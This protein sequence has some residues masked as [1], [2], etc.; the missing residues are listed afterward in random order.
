MILVGDLMQETAGSDLDNKTQAFVAN[1]YRHIPESSLPTYP[2]VLLMLGITG[3]PVAGYMTGMILPVLAMILI[4][5]FFYLRKLPK[6]TGMPPSA[7]KWLD[8]GNLFKHL[9]SLFLI[10]GLI[11]IFNLSVLTATLIT[12]ALA[13]IV[14]RFKVSDIWSLMQEAVEVKMLVNTFIVLVF[15]TFMEETGAM[16]ALPTFFAQFPIPL[17]ISFALLFFVGGV[18]SGS[19]GII[20]LAAPMA[21]LAIPNGGV[22][23]MVLLMTMSHIASLVSPT[24]VCVTIVADYYKIGIGGIVQRA[25][26]VMGVFFA[27]M[28]AYYPLMMWLMP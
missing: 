13:F 15:R 19:Q 12:I 9:W 23:L 21:F 4:V 24:H 26:P 28:L 14:Y 27:F 8:L 6:A 10:I 2:G 18:I 22:P 17:Y 20:S 5:Y 16:L 25:L 3:L 11:L 7:N 1:W